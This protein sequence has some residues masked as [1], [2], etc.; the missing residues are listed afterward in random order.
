M[1]DKYWVGG[2]GNWDASGEWALS[3][4]GAG[5]AGAPGATEPA[6]FDANSFSA[7][8]QIVS[9]RS[10]STNRCKSLNMTN[11]T[12]TPILQWT[13]LSAGNN[14][15]LTVSGNVTIPAGVTLTMS[16]TNAT[17]PGFLN[18]NGS[19]NLDVNPPFPFPT[20]S[21]DGV[22]V[23]AENSATVDL[24]R[25]LQA[26]AVSVS[27][28]A[29]FNT[30]NFNITAGQIFITGS[31]SNSTFNA[32]SSTLT[33]IEVVNNPTRLAQSGATGKFNPGTSTVIFDAPS[34]TLDTNNGAASNKLNNVTLT[35]D[36]NVIF[37]KNN[38][39]D[40]VL[41]LNPGATIQFRTNTTNTVDGTIVSNATSAKHI[42]FTVIG[43]TTNATLSSPINAVDLDFVDVDNNTA[44]GQTPFVSNGG[45]DNGGG[46]ILW[47]FGAAPVTAHGAFLLNFL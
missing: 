26:Y 34:A 42:I 1:A 37:E 7:S 47:T 12:N 33:L 19:G 14:P 44:S 36:T 20:A 4:G 9:I 35:E 10:G 30:N 8:G 16:A 41:T 17:T 5:G 45:I 11:V 28:A 46:N 2:T 31:G 18:I 29:T 43:G 6:I 21:V 24:Q 13:S 15:T 38:E 3:S 40:G 25:F 22:S 39:I 23:N 27:G 32:G